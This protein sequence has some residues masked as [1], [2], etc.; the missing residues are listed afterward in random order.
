MDTDDFIKDF[1]QQV[2]WFCNRIMEPVPKHPN[3]KEKIFKR[4][5]DVGW[6]RSVEVDTYKDLTK[7]DD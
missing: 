1:E 7:E 4:M 5:V 3:D 6:V 2:E